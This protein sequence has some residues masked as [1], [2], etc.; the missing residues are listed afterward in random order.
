M[1]VA[2]C[3]VAGIVAMTTWTADSVL[4][5]EAPA[6]AIVERRALDHATR[7]DQAG[8]ED[9]AMRALEHL[10]DEQPRSVSALVLL[11][12]MAERAGEPGRALSRAETAV[13]ADDSG[14]PALRQVWI[15]ILQAA[16]L[17]DS[18]L[19]VAQRWIME[20]PTA[21]SGYL[22]LS[23]LWARAGD[24]ERA[25][26][27]LTAGRVAIGSN[28]VFVQELAS[29][30]ADRGSYAAAAVEWRPMLAWGQ[31]GVEAVERGIRDRAAERPEA[32]DALRTELSGPEST[33]LEYKGGLQLALLLGETAWAREIVGRLVED[34][35]GPA[36][37]DV[38]RDYVARARDAGDLA[39]AAWAARSLVSRAN[40]DEEIRYWRAIEADLSYEAGDLEAARASFSRLISETN[41]GSD[42]YEVSLRRLHELTVAGDP[43]GAES[44]LRAHLVH[45]P[46][47]TRV[48]VEMSVS[49][50]LAWLARGRLK[51]ARA[52][53]A[54]VPP[55]DV[56]EAALQAAALGRVEILAGRPTAARVHL[57][58]AAGVPTDQ[59]GVR[60]EALELLALVERADSAGLVELGR[61]VVAAT[62]ASDPEPLVG[63]V[64]RWSAER[65]PGGE[66]MASFAAQEL[67]AAGW[68]RE[69]RM[70]R[71][72]IVDGWTG[73]PEA[74]RA[75]LEL[76]RADRAEDPA[77]AI[78]WLER[79]I[80]EYPESAVAPIARRL[81]VEARA[82][83]K[84][85]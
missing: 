51:R 44:L 72:A 62:G 73:S 84:G 39:G 54:R 46:E 37:L 28:R 74:P 29:L 9:E 43:E 4:G 41:P 49:S 25:I 83:G 24:Q 58:L 53:I 10:L 7:L 30:Q 3:A 36:A 67:Q 34:T 80:V 63:S 66:R 26:D 59:P 16:G 71:I 70:V 11:A 18:A 77:R 1:R 13:R 81:L 64:T 50:A 17:Q 2:W 42:L 23:G 79:L 85:A 32:L 69:A 35:P 61:G 47:R 55:A 31:P 48:A 21:V 40:S 6:D 5:Q 57:E 8:R 38:L 20:E 68:D 14:L 82:G 52:A 65:T 78:A 56:E 45:Y 75:L 60:I 33:I 76:A 12:Q 27:A 15:R 19:S 22:E